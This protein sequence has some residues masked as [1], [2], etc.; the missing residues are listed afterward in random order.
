MSNRSRGDFT[1]AQAIDHDMTMILGGTGKTG[2]RVAER[3]RAFRPSG[4]YRLAGRNAHLTDGVQQALGRVA[5]RLRPVRAG[6]G[7]ARCVEGGMSARDGRDDGPV[8]ATVGHLRSSLQVAGRGGDKPAALELRAPGVA[9][10]RSAM[11]D[12]R[13]S[14]RTPPVERNAVR[15]TGHDCL[16]AAGRLQVRSARVTSSLLID[17][18]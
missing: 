3:L 6:R 11:R 16:S 15:W 10:E 13:H 12:H 17:P 2:R 1:V 9:A 4:S 7:G 5:A 14:R 18:S 8:A